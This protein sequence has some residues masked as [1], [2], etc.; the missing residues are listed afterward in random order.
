MFTTKVNETEHLLDVI[1]KKVE[2]WEV[3]KD[4]MLP[5]MAIFSQEPYSSITG[6]LE[7][8]GLEVNEYCDRK[9]FDCVREN[10]IIEQPTIKERDDLRDRLLE[11]GEVIIIIQHYYRHCRERTMTI[12]LGKLITRLLCIYNDSSPF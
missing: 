8:N 11:F 12:L 6:I 9:L 5:E 3:L 1:N 2:D 10:R 4:Y 7:S